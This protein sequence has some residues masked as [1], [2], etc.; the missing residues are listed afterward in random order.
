MSHFS[1]RVDFSAVFFPVNS[2]IL[3]RQMVKSV[4][5]VISMGQWSEFERCPQLPSGWM[6]EGEPTRRE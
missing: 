1:R 5:I 6:L 3:C 2:Q 4:K